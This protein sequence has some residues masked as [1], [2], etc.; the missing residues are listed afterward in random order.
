MFT[1]DPE[2]GCLAWLYDMNQVCVVCCCQL[3][4][5]SISFLNLQL[6]PHSFS[7][8]FV[9]SYRK[10]TSAIIV[11]CRSTKI[12]GSD[13]W[14]TVSVISESWCRSADLFF[15]QYPVSW[16]SVSFSRYSLSCETFKMY[17]ILVSPKPAVTLFIKRPFQRN[18][19]M[20]LTM[21][22]QDSM[23]LI[24]HSL[25][26]IQHSILVDFEFGAVLLVRCTRKSCCSFIVPCLVFLMCYRVWIVYLFN[27]NMT[28]Q[29]IIQK[30][31]CL[32]RNIRNQ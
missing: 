13:F 14:V 16:R 21:L 11:H 6:L 29:L 4:R 28:V 20:I 31:H 27:F 1:P 5:W 32:I 25:V 30:L 17:K 26:L 10:S 9:H 7:R 8:R 18:D 24:K 2:D 12:A 19:S 3:S 15:A 23:V 22:I